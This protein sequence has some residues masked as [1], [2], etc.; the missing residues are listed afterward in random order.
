MREIPVCLFVC[1][2]PQAVT[3]GI[4]KRR[5]L[6]KS[7]VARVCNSPICRIGLIT[8]TYQQRGASLSPYLLRPGNRVQEG[9]VADGAASIHS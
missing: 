3:D 8:P 7:Q 4:S 2:L 6:C 9:T 1:G 5:V